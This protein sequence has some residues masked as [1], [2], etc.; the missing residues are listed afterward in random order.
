MN[1]KL[2]CFGLSALLLASCNGGG[3][4]DS[5]APSSIDGSAVTWAITFESNGGSAVSSLQVKNGMTA[6]K[7]KDPTKSGYTFDAWYSDAK[8]TVAFDWSKAITA[9]WKLYASWTTNISSSENSSIPNSE[10]SQS[11]SES[12]EASSIASS[13]T[14][15]AS[16]KGHGPEGS[17]L[18]SWYLVGSGSLWDTETGWTVADGVQLYSNPGNDNDKGCILSIRLEEGDMFKV[19][20]GGETWFGYEKV[21]PSD[22]DANLGKTNFAGEDDTYGGKNFKCLVSGTYDM[23]INGQGVFWIQAAQ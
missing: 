16:K 17:S 19:T 4:N 2:L 7:P 5:S 23:Y 11:S 13:S 14:I 1:K 3:G 10:M 9:N 6:A 8:L 18:V 20:D 12:G 21:D 15:D 22:S